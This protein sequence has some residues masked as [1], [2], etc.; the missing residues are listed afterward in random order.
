MLFSFEGIFSIKIFFNKIPFLPTSPLIIYHLGKLFYH[1]TGRSHKYK[2]IDLSQIE[3][4]LVVRLDQIGDLVMMTPFL[5][6]LRNNL[7]RAW[8]TLVVKPEML[9]LVETC[10]YVTE[11]LCFDWKGGILVRPFKRHWQALKMSY[12]HLW[13]RRFDLA[14]LPRWDVD[15]YHGTFLTY[16]SGAVR[17][18]GFS[19]HVNR[20][21]QL[22]NRGND[23]LLTHVLN[24][25]EPKHEVLRNLDMLRFLGM[26]VQ[27]DKLELWITKEDKQHAAQ[28]LSAHEYI[29][30]DSLMA[31]GP[32]ASEKGK[33]WPMSRFM[34]L[35]SWI[36]QNYGAKILVVGGREDEALGKA[37]KTKLK[38]NVINVIGK[39]TLRQTAALL[40]H[41]I[42][43][44]GNDS[45]PKHLAAA[46]NVPVIE[47]NRFPLGGN[48]L[49]LQS[50]YRFSP[51]GVPHRILQPEKTILPCPQVCTAKEAHCILGVT[52]EQVKKTV[53]DFI[54]NNYLNPR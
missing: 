4:I 22:I 37:L 28:I 21:K 15:F 11:V 50:S 30:K 9:N 45:G 26:L 24:N 5:R 13:R 38:D 27:N 17:R 20:L 43:F 23:H 12:L 7:P 1:L 36:I 39:T 41:S 44:I 10:P 46:M 19:E 35:G 2:E 51:F 42:L 29:Q 47:V 40:S 48:P 8:I 6:E 3:R 34:E 16:F 18:V 54:R 49:H 31:F 52:V 25:M 32:G 14:L 33:E 53:A